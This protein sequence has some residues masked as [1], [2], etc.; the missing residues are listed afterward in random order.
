M[1][2]IGFTLLPG[3]QVMSFAALS[4]FEFAN[5][6]MGEP[7]YDVHLLSE[8]GGL[9]RSS[10]GISVATEPFDDTNFDTLMVG[11]SAMAGSLTPGVIKFLR[12][13]LQRSRRIRPSAPLRPR[14][15]P[16]QTLLFPPVCN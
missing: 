10:I 14:A 11:G 9:I 16:S 1:Q 15:S 6:E 8:T 7:V 3:F 2:R 5:K 13:A 12:Q 4:V